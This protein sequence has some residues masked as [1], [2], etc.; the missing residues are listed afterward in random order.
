ML[1]R[2]HDHQIE[3]KVTEDAL[4]FILKQSYDQNYGASPLRR[5]VE[6]HIVTYISKMLIQGTLV[7]DS[8]LN[9]DVDNSEDNQCLK[10][11]SI[12]K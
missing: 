6:K 1:A 3:I 2:L 11:I 10:F 5:W 8:I 7:N 12:K 4:S 9:I